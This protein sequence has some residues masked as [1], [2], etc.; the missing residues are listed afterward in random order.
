MLLAAA[1]ARAEWQLSPFFGYTFKGDTTLVDVEDGASKVHWTFGATGTFIGSGPLGVE[2]LFIYTPSFFESEEV[3]ALAG[4]RSYAVMGNVVLAAPLHWN[5][6]GLRPLVS[7]GFGLMHAWQ[8]PQIVGLFPIDKNF[9][10]FNVGGG[11]IGFV[12]DRTGL[13]FDLRYYS[14]LSRGDEIGLGFGPLR[15]RYWTASVGV[16]FKLTP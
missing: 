7:G 15:L 2:G 14:S 16:V 1:P 10:G 3:S 6:Y 12:T 13:R 11:A 5:E 8:Q 4:S 9:F